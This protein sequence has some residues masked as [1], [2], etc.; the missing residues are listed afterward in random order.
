MPYKDLAKRAAMARIYSARSRA[1]N[2]EGN[3]E[4]QREWRRKWRENPE[5]LKKHLKNMAAYRKRH[6]ER[7]KEIQRIADK[8]RMHDP[9]KMERDT[10]YRLEHPEVI[11]A[12]WKRWRERN[13]EKFILMMRLHGHRR[14]VRQCNAKGTHTLEQWLQRV[15]F[16]GWHCAYCNK[17]LSVKTLRKDHN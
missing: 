1:R 11:E 6:P 15:H 3:R 12:G 5:N 4:Y 2:L 13:P 7:I 14:Y 9:R 17:E 16:Y 10:R 8:K